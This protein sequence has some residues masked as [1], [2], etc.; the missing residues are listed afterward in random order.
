[1]Q[2]GF[3][4]SVVKE[5]PLS[6]LNSGV[7]S[8]ILQIAHI[9]D[10]IPVWGTQVRLRDSKLRE[11]YKSEPMLASAIYGTTARYASF[12]YILTGPE[13]QRNI[14][15][16]MLHNSEHGKGWNHLMI[17]VIKD[18]LT[19]DNA[20]WA[21]TIRLTNDDPT[22]P[23]VQMNHLDSARCTRTGRWEEPIIYQDLEGGYHLMKWY[24]VA[25]F[26]EYPDSDERMRGY[27]EC[28]VSRVLNGAQKMR[29]ILTYEREKISGRNPKAIH[30]VGGVQ[31]RFIDNHMELA[32]NRAD[33]Q[34]LARYM[35]PVII[36]AL[37]PTARV[38]HEQI[39]LAALPEGWDKAEEH[40][41]YVVLLALAIG[42][43]PQDI[44]PLPGHG[45][46]SSSQSETL[47][48]KG[49]GKGPALFI[50]N[51][52]HTMNF[53]GIMPK[54]VS[55]EYQEQDLAENEQLTQLMW[56]RSQVLRL[57]VGANEKTPGVITPEVARQLMRDW[58]DLR[59]E[60]LVAMG[61]TDITPLG[62]IT[63][64]EKSLIDNT[65]KRIK[66]LVWR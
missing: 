57:L 10:D 56:R 17:K 22:S 40:R 51:V 52:Q 41:E 34:M 28:A 1:M 4:N 63:S 61:E 9:A 59:D 33:S 12:K 11:F 38:S 23:V 21:E 32:Q 3:F 58:G 5:P 25:E 14:V 66:Q 2:D 15:Q 45:L 60:Y 18:Y 13:R 19:Q 20:S 31:Q 46:G 65:L 24:Q 35:A 48:Q 26:T 55:F 7:A 53:H 62:S 39:D 64:D 49:R 27:Q 16:R 42:V 30:L 36:S 29:D 47:A 8:L 37:D 54:T 44:A 6:G 43:D 50:S